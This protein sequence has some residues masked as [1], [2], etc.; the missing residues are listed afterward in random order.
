MI[1]PRSSR[2]LMRWPQEIL[3]HRDTEKATIRKSRGRSLFHLVFSVPLCLRGSILFYLVRNASVLL[4]ARN[5]VAGVQPREHELDTRRPHGRVVARVD[6]ER[7]LP[8]LRHTFEP[9]G[10]LRRR[11]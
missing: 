9:L 4:C 1:P 3:N 5:A 2:E 10:I 7:L 11:Q 6:L 8:R